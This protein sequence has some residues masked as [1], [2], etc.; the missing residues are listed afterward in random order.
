M[1]PCPDARFSFSLA[2]GGG[3]QFLNLATNSFQTPIATGTGSTMISEDIAIDPIRNFILSPTEAGDYEI[4]KTTPTVALYE[5][6]V[7][8]GA[9]FDSSAEDCTTGIALSSDEFTGN[10]FIADLTQAT[11]TS[12]TPAGTWSA[13]SQLQTLPEFVNLAAGTSGGAHRIPSSR[14]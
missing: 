9:V 11:F 14:N 8:A 3:Y 5:N 10:I 4:V 6:S 13:P 7:N 2:T 1:A 12:G